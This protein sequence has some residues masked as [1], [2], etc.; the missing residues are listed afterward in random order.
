MCA[1]V[2]VGGGGS[3]VCRCSWWWRWCTC[4]CVCARARTRACVCVRVSFCCCCRLTL[5]PLRLTYRP[6]QHT[7][8]LSSYVGGATVGGSRLIDCSASFIKLSSKQSAVLGRVTASYRFQ[9]HG[10]V[11]QTSGASSVQDTQWLRCKAETIRNCKTFTPSSRFQFSYRA[12]REMK[13][14]GRGVGGQR[15]SSVWKTSELRT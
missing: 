3:D 7:S 4:V 2:V 5:P 13:K 15:F 8:A 9:Q 1:V 14:S 12:P 6:S 11:M 10:R